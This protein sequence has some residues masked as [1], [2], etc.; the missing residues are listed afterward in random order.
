LLTLSTGSDDVNHM[1]SLL[2]AHKYSGDVIRRTKYLLFSQISLT[3]MSF[4]W[5][6]L[7]KLHR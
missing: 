4:M 3:S 1:I 5:L 2:F 7:L 6:F